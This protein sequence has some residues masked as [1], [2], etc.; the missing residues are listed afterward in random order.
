MKS[1]TWFCCLY[2]LPCYDYYY[3][4]VVVDFVDPDIVPINVDVTVAVVDD[5]LLN[6][7]DDDE[8]LSRRLIHPKSVQIDSQSKHFRF[9]ASSRNE[10]FAEK[11]KISIIISLSGG[12]ILKLNQTIESIGL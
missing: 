2:H 8:D 3:A 4:D 11:K 10:K 7:G 6:A 1:K 12:I 5:D 9:L